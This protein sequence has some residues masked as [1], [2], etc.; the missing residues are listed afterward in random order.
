MMKNDLEDSEY[1]ILK[2][3]MF[4]EDFAFYQKKVPGLFVM[5]GTKNESKN[6]IH[7]LHSCYFNFDEVVLS[8]GVELYKKVLK[9]MK[10]N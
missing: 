6:Y 4:A 3:M 8:K 5:L 7:P 2:P 10:I 1:K 9:V